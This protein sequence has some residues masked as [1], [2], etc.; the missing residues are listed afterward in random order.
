MVQTW[1]SPIDQGHGSRVAMACSTF[2][3]RLGDL[4]HRISVVAV[5]ADAVAEN[6]IVLVPLVRTRTY[7]HGGAW[8][9]ARRRSNRHRETG[10]LRSPAPGCMPRSLMPIISAA[11]FRVVFFPSLS[12]SRCNCI[13]PP[14][15]GLR[16]RV[17]TPYSL[18]LSPLKRRTY[19][20]LA[21]ILFIG[22]DRNQK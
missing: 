18:L 11:C 20:V 13:A 10:A 8:A 15:H 21:P 16:V 5:H 17:A 19:G 14:H 9:T 6:V 3:G 22:L 7:G 4:N 12:K 1:Q 2:D